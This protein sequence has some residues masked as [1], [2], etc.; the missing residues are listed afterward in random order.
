M[1]EFRKIMDRG[2]RSARMGRGRQP[3]EGSQDPQ[4][5][6]EPKD[7]QPKEAFQD[8][9][10]R[11][12]FHYPQAGGGA[13]S[14]NQEKLSVRLRDQVHAEAKAD[15]RENQAAVEQREV[16]YTQLAEYLKMAFSS[17]QADKRF[18]LQPGFK[19]IE[20]IVDSDTPNDALFLKAIH[21]ADS[22]DLMV[23]PSVNVAIY[24]I[25]MAATLEF[26]KTRQVEIGMVALLHDIGMA[27][28]PETLINKKNLTVDE[29]LVFK[30][31]PKYGYDIL[32]AF[33]AEHAY[34]AECALQ[35]HER[36]DGSG[37]PLGLA[38]DEIHE[39]AQ[40]IGLVDIYEALIHARPQREKILHF[41]AVKE[42]IKTGKDKF[43]HRLLKALLNTFSIFPLNSYVRLNSGAIGRV[44]RTYPDQPVRPKVR[45]I[46]DSQSKKV[47]TERFINLPE[48]SLLYIVDAVSEQELVN[49]SDASYLVTKPGHRRPAPGETGGE[50]D[51]HP[52]SDVPDEEKANG[53]KPVTRLTEASFAKPK[54]VLPKKFL[55]IL[56]GIFVAAGIAWQLLGAMFVNGNHQ[57]AVETTA[58][59][60]EKAKTGLPE[61]TVAYEVRSPVPTVQHTTAQ[62]E[63]DEKSLG[64]PVA[65]EAKADVEVAVAGPPANFE[66][67]TPGVNPAQKIG[68][69]EPGR[70]PYSILL[71]HFRKLS[72]V[73]AIIAEYKIKGF[74][75]FWVKDGIWYRVLCG[76][77]TDGEQARRVI[78]EFHLE[79]VLAE[80][81]R[82]ATWVAGF[83]GEQALAQKR[84]ELTDMG[85]S[86]Y[87]IQDD[88][89]NGHLYVGA[90]YTVEGARNQH[91][92]LKN[93]GVDSRIVER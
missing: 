9:Q 79:D 73:E 67:S 87:V 49:I 78:A 7:P 2:K 68:P 59:V 58:R 52:E 37:Y 33:K 65:A 13:Q 16:L 66:K 12:A 38:A 14:L 4:P 83:A 47:L 39:Y 75:P 34:L 70:H 54:S 26:S 19:I 90:F 45:I 31:R 63:N 3:R 17:I 60:L 55:L 56:A 20:K 72:T 51:R 24:A 21:D 92:K 91:T 41:Y 11:E 25:K 42:V 64:K 76:N 22:Y 77:Y 10:P 18:L 6:E 8:P 57:G 80:P 40:I 32:Q 1:V 36:L 61:Q 88:A 84:A 29:F 46:Y 23:S 27:K 15:P 44:T 48:H 28:I 62:T 89:G 35:I 69:P 50:P 30:E 86:S 81:T 74:D 53:A 43:Q 85:F 5:R 93:A 82:Y 71:A